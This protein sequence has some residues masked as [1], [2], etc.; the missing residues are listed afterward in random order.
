[1][2]VPSI[3]SYFSKCEAC[4]CNDKMKLINVNQLIH[5]PKAWQFRTHK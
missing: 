4:I 5:S 3:E 1:L 2:K